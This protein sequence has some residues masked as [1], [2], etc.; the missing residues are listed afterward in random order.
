MI[1]ATIQRK[2]NLALIQTQ[3]GQKAIIPWNTLCNFLQKHKIKPTNTNPC[4]NK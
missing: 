2:G 1:K 4:K 3:Q